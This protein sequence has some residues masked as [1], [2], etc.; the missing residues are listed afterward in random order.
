MSIEENKKLVQKFYDA[1]NSEEFDKLHDLCHQDFVFYSQ[2]DTPK[3]GVNG[4]IDA[5]KKHF[6]AFESFTFPVEIMVAEGNRVAVYLTWNPKGQKL[7]CMGVPPTGKG[8]KISVF[9]LLTIAD[10]KIIEKRAHF[11]VADV[12]RQLAA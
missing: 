1:I 5:E 12:R 9:C 3:P 10:G 2:V 7:E 4:F 8:C 11:D 6:D